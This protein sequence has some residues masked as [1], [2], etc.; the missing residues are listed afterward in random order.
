MEDSY[1]L[2]AKALDALPGGFPET[3]SH[4]ELQLVRKAF[5][6]EEVELAGKMTRKYETAEGLAARVGMAEPRVKNILRGLLSRRL[7]RE[8][9]VEGQRLY[10]LG[11]FVVGW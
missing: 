9:V 1:A 8:K 3:P 10:R 7:V 6:A 5:S 2:L 4:V 11:P